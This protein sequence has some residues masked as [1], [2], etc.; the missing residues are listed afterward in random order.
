MLGSFG[1][2]DAAKKQLLCKSKR[3]KRGAQMESVTLL[4]TV[5]EAFTFD[6]I[7][8]LAKTLMM[9]A[10]QKFPSPCDDTVYN[11]K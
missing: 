4:F 7:V 6:N 10:Q 8:L 9:Q 3:I 1:N 11:L 5:I 2:T